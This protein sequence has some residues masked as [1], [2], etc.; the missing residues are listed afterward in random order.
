MVLPGRLLTCQDEMLQD[1][2]PG[3]FQK[4]LW[5][6][7]EYRFKKPLTLPD[8]NRIRWHLYPEIRIDNLELFPRQKAPG[9]VSVPDVVKVMDIHQEQLARGLRDGHRVIH[10]VAGSGKTLILPSGRRV[11][12]SFLRNR[13][14]RRSIT[15]RIARKGEP[16]HRDADIS[17]LVQFAVPQQT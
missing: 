6:M 5:G 17:V 12:A 9:Q 16:P 14:P 4:R 10:G 13:G 15:P 2:D 7:F 1:T 3:E 11:V 8:L